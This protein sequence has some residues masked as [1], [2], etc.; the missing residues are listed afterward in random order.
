MPAKIPQPSESFFAHCA[1][2]RRESSI[3]GVSSRVLFSKSS[4]VRVSDLGH[5]AFPSYYDLC[6]THSKSHKRLGTAR[7]AFIS[8][9]GVALSTES[10]TVDNVI[11]LLRY[12]LYWEVCCR[13]LFKNV[14][15]DIVSS[16]SSFA[17]VAYKGCL[18]PFF[19]FSTAQ[20]KLRHFHWP[21]YQQISR[22][23]R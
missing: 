17:C 1:I 6:R 13:S 2:S 15:A 16:I 7:P 11:P 14:A 12:Q 9:A 4:Q 18:T 8:N 23:N 22:N 21:S 5:Y 10:A 19:F 20:A 3:C